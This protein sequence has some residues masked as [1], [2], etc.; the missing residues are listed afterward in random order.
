MIHIHNLNQNV[1][2]DDDILTPDIEIS[3]DDY[4]SMTL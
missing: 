1:N 2:N 3:T 4:Q